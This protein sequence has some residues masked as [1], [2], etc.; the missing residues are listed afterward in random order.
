MTRL[1]TWLRVRLQDAPDWLVP[2][3]TGLVFTALGGWGVYSLVVIGEG[4]SR[5]GANIGVWLILLLGLLCLALAAYS[6]WSGL[7]DD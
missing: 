2:L 4:F 3:V 7:R 5:P 1:F 6:A